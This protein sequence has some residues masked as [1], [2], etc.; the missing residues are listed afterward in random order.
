MAQSVT[1]TWTTWFMQFDAVSNYTEILLETTIVLLIV[2]VRVVYRKFCKPVKPFSP[3]SKPKAFVAPNAA[4]RTRWDGGAEGVAKKVRELG[5][6]GG[7]DSVEPEQ[8]SKPSNEIKGNTTF[9]RSRAQLASLAKLH[10]WEQVV[11]T[12]KDW[13]REGKEMSAACHGMAL[14][15]CHKLGDWKAAMVA[16][17]ALST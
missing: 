11:C 3:H 17:D 14:G 13:R 1:Q 16:F 12:W 15:A 4:R 9:D 7:R 6:R 5:S 8:A 2:V 10:H